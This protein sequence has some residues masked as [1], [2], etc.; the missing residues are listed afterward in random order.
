MGCPALFL[1][2]VKN[3]SLDVP[4]ADGVIHT[5]FLHDGSV[6]YLEAIKIDCAAIKAMTDAMAGT[7]KPFVQSSATGVMGTTNSALFMLSDTFDPALK[8]CLQ[9]RTILSSFIK[10][11]DVLGWTSGDTGPVP[12]TEELP[13]DPGFALV[14]RVNPERVSL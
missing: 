13:V 14:T 4:A 9:E 8:Y 11:E 10:P 3:F 7:D 5:A 1:L 6:P 2:P 12:V